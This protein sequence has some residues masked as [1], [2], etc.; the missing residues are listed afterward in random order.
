MRWC[1]RGI[2]HDEAVR[3]WIKGLKEGGEVSVWPKGD[4]CWAIKWRR[5]WWDVVMVEAEVLVYYWAV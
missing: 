5:G 4:V 1:G 2:H 3:A